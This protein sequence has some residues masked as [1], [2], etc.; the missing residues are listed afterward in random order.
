MLA[1]H[2]VYTI[3]HPESLQPLLKQRGPIPRHQT[4]RWVTAD[5]LFQKA[6]CAGQDMAIVFGDATHCTRLKFWGL[7]SS[8]HVREDGTDFEVTD[9]KPLHGKR[10]Q[11]L[12]LRSTQRHIAPG[13]IRPYAIVECPSFLRNQAPID[14]TNVSVTSIPAS[15][16]TTDAI[17]L[18]SFG[19]WGCGSATD[20]LVKAVN[21][22]EH[23]R[24]FDPPLW[25]DVRISRSVRAAGFRDDAFRRLLHDHYQWMSDLGNQR[26]QEGRRGIWIKNPA[27]AADLL[28]LALDD[29]R[30]RVIF[31]C[32][33]PYPAYCHRHTV[34]EL[35]LK[36]AQSRRTKI[37]IEEWPGGEPDT[38]TVE[39]PRSTLTKVQRQTQRSLPIPD[40]M[41]LD[42]AASLPWGSIATLN[43]GTQQEKILAG[44]ASFNAAGAHLRLFSDRRGTRAAARA[45]REELGYSPV[46]A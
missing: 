37:R 16:K 32:S 15:H 19:Y 5:A 3:A 31:F 25:V 41:T 39:V 11:Q 43:C 21:A 27:A 18:F 2:A 13:F 12:V 46:K 17:T 30:R 26:V 4:K 20:M 33:C 42:A 14:A 23:S 7:I 29:P 6:L 22:A 24:G 34:T 28:Q 45:F 40:S 35:L 10:T 44:P 38:I 9:L 36:E 1:E 8:L